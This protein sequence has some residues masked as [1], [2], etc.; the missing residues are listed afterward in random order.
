MAFTFTLPLWGAYLGLGAFVGLLDFLGTIKN[1]RIFYGTLLIYCLICAFTY[2]PFLFDS[3]R[4]LFPPLRSFIQISNPILVL[5]LGIVWIF[6]ML[7]ISKASWGRRFVFT[8][9][10]LIFVGLPHFG[11]FYN[12][13]ENLPNEIPLAAA[14]QPSHPHIILYIAD[15][16]N[17]DEFYNR[18]ED[19]NHELTAFIENAQKFQNF[20]SPI[21]EAQPSFA[22]LLTGLNPVHS[23]VRFNFSSR[24]ASTNFF[25]QKSLLKKF[26]D[27]GY[28]IEY[29]TNS[30]Q[31]NFLNSTS[32]F[33]EVYAPIASKT[34]VLFSPFFQNLISHVFIP[35]F[36]MIKL[37]PVL[38]NDLS[39]PAGYSEKDFIS[40]LQRQLRKISTSTAPT[41]LIV[42]DFSLQLPGSLSYPSYLRTDL[43]ADGKTPFSYGSRSAGLGRL[44]DL[45]WDQR[46]QF[47][48]R[49][50]NH[51][52]ALHVKNVLNPFFQTIEQL[53]LRTSSVVGL[54]STSSLDFW[55]PERIYPQIKSPQQG[56][57]LILDSR[58]ERGFFAVSVPNQK[59]RDHKDLA[60]VID[61]FPTL[62]DYLQVSTTNLDGQSLLPRIKSARLTSNTV[63]YTE[64]GLSRDSLFTGQFE[65]LTPMLRAFKIYH[66]QQQNIFIDP[67]FE[68]DFV[69][70]KQL[71]VSED[72][73]R[74]TVYPTF[75]GYNEFLCD[76]EKDR[77]CENNLLS[78]NESKANQLRKKLLQF[79][80]DDIDSGHL[81]PLN[82]GTDSLTLLNVSRPAP[83]KTNTQY[84]FWSL[85]GL[86]S[87]AR[88]HDIKPLEEAISFF[89]EEDPKFSHPAARLALEGLMRTCARTLYFQPDFIPPFLTQVTT[90]PIFKTRELPNQLRILRNRCEERIKQNFSY[91]D[92]E[93][94]EKKSQSRNTNWDELTSQSYEGKRFLLVQKNLS[95][96]SFSEFIQKLD[97]LFVVEKNY[98]WPNLTVNHYLAK[99]KWLVRH[100][101]PLEQAA[102]EIAK[103]LGNEDL[104]EGW[105]YFLA[106]RLEEALPGPLPS[107][108]KIRFARSIWSEEILNVKSIE[109]GLVKLRIKTY[110]CSQNKDQKMCLDSSED[111]KRS[112][113]GQTWEMWTQGR[114]AK[115]H[116]LNKAIG[117]FQSQNP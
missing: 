53:N 91:A 47:N 66:L 60:G 101:V 109:L 35:K 112:K 14:S 69:A 82:L 105:F 73:W 43:P 20:I 96:K 62:L 95:E 24:L 76:V 52:T 106:D 77:F 70:Q 22:S 90:L 51:L 1:K 15:S 104:S 26:K 5:A 78:Q 107:I 33:G 117:P 50:S 41:L 8:I 48:R 111:L 72:R 44:R 67:K 36:I 56:S 108:K 85:K 81:P 86:E 115:D 23:E 59:G 99:W 113:W 75:F 19:W 46:V 79:V 84:W 68:A 30:S 27:Q 12:A 89:A 49:L 39:F 92:V 42:H 94:L 18:R 87:L 103:E 45:Q 32:A 100:Q 3:Y 102:V 65:T 114:L 16:L 17:R 55:Q 4:W 116:P 25:E 64:T 54:L 2:H 11:T 63:Y 57:S 93:E 74:Y 61:V 88:W 40:L 6:A 83:Q 37:M 58:S 71:A 34:D 29:I 7:V 13:P 110:F 38:F 21:A 28:R 97:A 80:K 98:R 9:F 31:F 10:A